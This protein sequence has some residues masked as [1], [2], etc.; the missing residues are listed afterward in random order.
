M[1]PVTDEMIV[2]FMEAMQR[3]KSVSEMPISRAREW[4]AQQPKP[5]REEYRVYTIWDDHGR[6]LAHGKRNECAAA[7]GVQK[8][9]ISDQYNRYLRGVQTKRIYSVVDE[10]GDD[11]DKITV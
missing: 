7:I 8:K 4:I 3:L 6:L 1:R 2:R 10:R 9:R 11:D 5:G